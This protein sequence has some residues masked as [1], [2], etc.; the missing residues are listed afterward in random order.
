MAGLCFS[1]EKT[2]PDFTLKNTDG[3]FYSTAEQRD[4]RGFIVI[5]TCNHC[6]FARLYT[7]RL[8]ELNERYSASGIPLIAINS[9]DT[10]VY[11]DE[12]F[13][14]MKQK[15]ENEKFNFPY[16]QDASQE[17]G[18]MFKAEHTPTAYVLWKE[19]GQWRIR[20]QGAIDDNGEHPENAH[21]YI[22]LAV[23]EL[24]ENKKVTLPRTESFGCRIFYRKDKR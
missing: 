1:Q 11:E 24:L 9:M 23:N 2:V 17:I 21:S 5:F 19:N 16:L 3:L 6:P 13:G 7:G 18:R 20:Y 4:A 10:L 22:A 12:T 8:N 15:S 14:L